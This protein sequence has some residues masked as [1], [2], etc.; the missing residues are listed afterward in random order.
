MNKAA[1]MLCKGDLNAAKSELDELLEDQNLQVIQTDSQSD[2]LIPDHLVNLLLY[3]LLVTSKYLA[4]NLFILS[5]LC[6]KQQDG[7][8]SSEGSSLY[9]RHKCNRD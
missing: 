3:F 1:V 8:T 7:Q 4:D 9:S 5:T 6:R 2:D